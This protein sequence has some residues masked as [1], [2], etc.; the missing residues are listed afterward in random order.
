MPVIAAEKFL[1]DAANQSGFAIMLLHFV[2]AVNDANVQ[3]KSQDAFARQAAATN[4]KNLVKQRWAPVGN[5]D[6]ARPV[7]WKCL[8]FV[9]LWR[10]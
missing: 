8:L 6:V 3:P 9:A 1:E 10:V 7:P 4:F 5:L 2:K